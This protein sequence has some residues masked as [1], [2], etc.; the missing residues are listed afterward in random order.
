TTKSRSD[1]ADPMDHALEERAINESPPTSVPKVQAQKAPPTSKSP[2]TAKQSPPPPVKSAPSQRPILIAIDP[3]HGGE[4]PGATGPNGTRE[5]DVVLQIA[6]RLQKHIDA[7]P[8]MR[9][10]LTRA[11][12]CCI[13]AH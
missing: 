9:T 11:W 8:N 13:H 3:G 5:K 2:S 12:G 10:Y 1:D 7:Q 4:D 6:R